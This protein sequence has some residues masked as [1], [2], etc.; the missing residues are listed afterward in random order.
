MLEHPVAAWH[1]LVRSRNPAALEALM[2]EDAVFVSP[3]VHNPQRGKKVAIAYLTAAFRVFFNPT[4]RY[5]REIVGPGDAMLEFETEIDGILVN[6][7]DIIKWNESG[8]IV[9]FKDAS[10]AEQAIDLCNS[11]VIA[12]DGAVLLGLLDQVGCDNAKRE[13]Y[14]TDIVGIV[15]VFDL[16][17]AP[18][19]SRSVREVMRPVSYFPESMPL[20]E[21]LVAIQRTGEN[22]AGNV[23]EYGGGPR[24][25]TQLPPNMISGH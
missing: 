20:D 12:V 11:G 3:V 17:Q 14:L 7:V 21:V 23:D 10:P 19:L 22:L 24:R 8:R 18:D 15:H 13:Y 2:D 25:H 4:F 5:V 9:E 6:G 1:E 16:L